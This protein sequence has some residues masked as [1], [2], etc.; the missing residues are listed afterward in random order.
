MTW[1]GFSE[2]RIKDRIDHLEDD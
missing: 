2:E 1:F